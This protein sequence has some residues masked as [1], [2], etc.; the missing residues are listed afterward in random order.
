MVLL[1]GFLL[2]TVSTGAIN[3]FRL[4]AIFPLHRT[5]KSSTPF[6]TDVRGISDLP[7]CDCLFIE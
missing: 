2:I 5:S 7:P 6:A 3:T 1:F 4:D